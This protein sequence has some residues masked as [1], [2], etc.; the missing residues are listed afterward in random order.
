MNSCST[1]STMM[2]PKGSTWN[3]CRPWDLQ[4]DD[5][6]NCMMDS[7]NQEALDIAGADIK[8]FRLLGVHEQTK[9]IDL[10]G[11][12]KPISG[13]SSEYY[14]ASNAFTAFKA[15]WKSLQAG[16]DAIVASSYIGYDF[17]VI[18]LPSGRQ[19]YAIPAN[20]RYEIST[21]RIKQSASA[22]QRVTKA[23]IER[24][25]DN[26]TW[27]GVAIVDLPNDDQLNTIYFK[28]STA[29]R[30]WRIRPI[31]FN[32]DHC[33]QWVVQCLEMHEYAATNLTNLQDKILMENRDRSYDTTGVVIKAY[34]ELISLSSFMSKMM[35]GPDIQTT[36]YIIKV[37]FNSTVASL[38]RP[39]VIGD[40]IEIPNLAQ[41]NTKLEK[42][43]SYLEVTDVTWDVGSFTPG[44]Q[45]LMLQIT[46][47]PAI[48]SQETQ[49]L[50]GDL[51]NNMQNDLSINNDG[52][53]TKYQ[54]FSNIDQT[55]GA[56]SKSQ[57]PERG[58]EQS[59]LIREFTNEEIEQ[60][61][62]LARPAIKKMQPNPKAVYVEDG[63]PKNGEPYI[64]GSDFPSNPNNGDYFRMVYQGTA[65][66]VPARLYRYS[67]VKARWIWMET[68]KRESYNNQKALV[69]E[70]T[71]TSKNNN[72]NSTWAGDIK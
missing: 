1:N 67:S 8:V 33:D 44:W 16:P 5:K 31:I 7:L 19:R 63:L 34:Y 22:N 35:L 3:G 42:I 57:V 56:N 65:I 26:I 53:N 61:E 69:E 60:V 20:Q 25:D 43:A 12:G 50:F 54:D 46:A 15:Q 64:E 39:I 27:Y 6:S 48:A 13:G 23:R 38:T 10:T 68:D 59:N 9:L 66:K 4:S 52:N 11:Q 45:P 36:Q 49:D 29:N 24:S 41:Y 30:Y 47:S 40:I 2:C 58:A 18:R 28:Q 55:I 32:G 17:G 71:L 62:I 70:Y 72:K 21:I 51:A 37:N 14:P